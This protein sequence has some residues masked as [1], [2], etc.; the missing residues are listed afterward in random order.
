MRPDEELGT[1]P[2]RNEVQRTV[3]AT[4]RAAEFLELRALQ[5]QTGQPVE[6]FGHVVVK[7]LL[8]NALDA[9]ETAGRAPAVDIGTRTSDG[10]VSVTVSDN[11]AGIAPATVTDLCDFNLLVSDKAHYRGPARGA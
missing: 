5:A 7:E 11:G 8:D 9:A 10:L 3:F 6:A 1:G 4:P 2:P